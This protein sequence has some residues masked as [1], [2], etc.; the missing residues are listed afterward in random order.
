MSLLEFFFLQCSPGLGLDTYFVGNIVME[1]VINNENNDFIITS[2]TDRSQSLV[3]SLSRKKMEIF[4]AARFVNSNNNNHMTCS[5]VAS[6]IWLV[7]DSTDEQCMLL[8]CFYMNGR[9][10]LI[11]IVSG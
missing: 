7:S 11:D 2:F 6:D 3:E 9:Q 1:I 4:Q 5:G 8:S 10:V